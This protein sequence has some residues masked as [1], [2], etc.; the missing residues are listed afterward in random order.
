MAHRIAA[1]TML[2]PGWPFDQ[3]PLVLHGAQEAVLIGH[4]APPEGY[5]RVGELAGRPLFQG[6]RLPE[7]AANT[8]AEVAGHLAAL[9][10]LPAEPLDSVDGYARLLLHEAFHVYQQTGLRA[11]A[12]APLPMGEAMG[13]YPENDP[14]N[15]AMAVVENRW[16]IAALGGEE[17]A[18][19]AVLSVRRHRH[20]RLERRGLGDLADYE[21][22][23]EYSEG[24][25]TYVEL[26]AGLPLPT[27]TER[28]ALCNRGGRWAAYQRFYY[29]GAALALLLDQRLPGWQERFAAGGVTLQGL[30]ESVAGAALPPVSRV[31]EP[32]GFTAVLEEEERGEAERRAKIDSLLAELRS[33]PGVPVAIHLP[34]TAGGVMWDPR[35]VMNIAPGARLHPTHCGASGP[36]GLRVEIHRL[37]L[38]ERGANGR[39][40]TL[41]LPE[42]PAGRLEA[43]RFRL[44]APGL[45][46]DAP[47]GTVEQ[48]ADGVQIWL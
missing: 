41:R 19:A 14:P 34:P 2:W 36:E 38:E 5:R 43:G 24:S 13:R 46:I 3:T 6:P 27:L 35:S 11:V 33:G 48:G 1:E 44:E 30:V 37:C 16:L 9:A 12:G 42:R 7:M 25:P 45:T 31:L 22:F 18:V 8:A 10:M 28:L 17:G 32:Q 23:V 26:Q 20:R 47:S 40:L 15:N 29:T 39:T 4:P 21:R